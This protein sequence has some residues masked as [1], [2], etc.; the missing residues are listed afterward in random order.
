MIKV[1][2]RSIKVKIILLI[3]IGTITVSILFSAYQYLN[4]KEHL[5]Q[6]LQNNAD[7]IISRVSQNL[8]IP[9]WE[10]DTKWIDT[11]ID[12]EMMNREI[13]AVIVTGEENINIQKKRNLQWEVIDFKSTLD[14]GF[15]KRSSAIIHND[16][17]IGHVTIYMTNKFLD[18]SLV[19]AAKNSFASTLL[20]VVFL[21][22]AIY[23]ILNRMILNPLNNILN[24][25]KAVTRGDYL[26]KVELKQHDEIGELGNGFNYMIDNVKEREVAIKKS[27][28][29]YRS[30]I[31]NIQVAV[32][33]HDAD[34]RIRICNNKAQE[35]L[36]LS[37]A[38]LLGKHAIDPQ[39]HFFKE[40]GYLLALD[41]YPVNLVL[42]RKKP[43]RN[44]ILGVNRPK[45]GD[46][47]WV[48]VN[49]DPRYHNKELIE[50]IV[51]FIDITEEKNIQKALKEVHNELEDKVKLRTM[52]LTVAN[53]KLKELDK[54]KSMFIASMSHELRTPLNSIIGFTS[55]ILQGLSGEISDI[56]KDQLSRVKRAGEHLL[57][58]I[59]DVIDISKVE[60]GRI[61]A[62]P[63]LFML[64]ELLN[65]IKEEMDL[66]AAQKQLNIIINS[67]VDIE[68]FTD[69]RRLYQCILNYV[70]NAVKF[71]ERA[72]T[73]EI[74]A[75]EDDD[76]LEISVIDNGIG[77]K[78]D[79]ISKLFE[80]FERLESHLRVKA[81][82]TGLG[83][84]LTKKIT[85][86]LLRGSVFVKSEEGKG[87]LFGL[88]IP[89]KLDSEE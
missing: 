4:Q 16:Q 67:S 10:I 29:K 40:D 41:E 89:K 13:Y 5:R 39:W 87:S 68:L 11:I 56:Q 55:V 61:E 22:I 81:G 23:L 46:K 36:G 30:L 86:E 88:I 51:T 52:E 57:S 20:L 44:Y 72:G 45:S 70:S 14:D 19:E 66:L 1:V 28:E 83:L 18:E 65:E 49:A 74:K 53:K 17:E 62:E 15:L 80:A 32:V 73:I 71:T 27:E 75:S 3:F 7:R 82:G 38:E 21:I 78:E 50:V 35:I 8:V 26:H 12:T 31:K 76:K 64:N 25:V 63:E 79:D 54:L 43:L 77:I 85:T 47:V 37:E 33:V 69:R 6:L 24:T 34:T 2:M 60:A 9:L 48:L 84:Y 59:T 58:L 42:S